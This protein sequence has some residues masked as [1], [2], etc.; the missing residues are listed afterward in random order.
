MKRRRARGLLRRPSLRERAIANL[1][2]RFAHQRFRI[3]TDEL[4][5]MR[6]L[7]ELARMRMQLELVPDS[8]RRHR[9]ADLAQL[10]RG[11]QL[12]QRDLGTDSRFGQQLVGLL[13]QE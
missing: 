13:E 5:A 2:D 10:A 11:I 9:V 1:S 3:F 6:E 4:R 7:S 8:S 12:E